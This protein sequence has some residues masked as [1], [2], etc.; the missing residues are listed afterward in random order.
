M[1]K[2]SSLPILLLLFF[3][4]FA[5]NG[6]EAHPGDSCANPIAIT[7]IAN[8]TVTD[9]L[10]TSGDSVKWFSFTA[11]YSRLTIETDLSI[12]VADT[13]RAYLDSLIIYKGNTCGSLVRVAYSA[14]K[15]GSDTFPSI[16]LLNFDS[17]YKYYAKVIRYRVGVRGCHL[18]PAYFGLAPILLAHPVFPAGPSCPPCGPNLLCNG[19]FEDTNAVIYR[20]DLPY[21]YDDESY[22]YPDTAAVHSYCIKSLNMRYGTG[23]SL[24]PVAPDNTDIYLISEAPNCRS[25]HCTILSGIYLMIADA[26]SNSCTSCS[27]RGG[28]IPTN[29]YIDTSWEEQENTIPGAMYQFSG[30]LRDADLG[31]TPGATVSISINSGII[32]SDVIDSTNYNNWTNVTYCWATTSSTA[33]IVI[34]GQ[35]APSGYGYDYETDSLTFELSSLPVISYTPGYKVCAGDSVTMTSSYLYLNSP[36]LTY[37]WAPHTGLSCYT[38]PE[39]KASP[40]VTTVY[41]CIIGTTQGSC[42]DTARVK[43][44]ASK[45]SISTS[46]NSG[47]YLANNGS[48]TV[49][50]TGGVS[51]YTYSWNPSGQTTATATG[52]SAGSYTI[53]VTDA[54]GC[55]ASA[56]VTITAP[57]AFT[58]TMGSPTN[59][60]C[61]GGTGSVTVTA[62][63][64]TSPY[65]YLW[66]PSGGT[67]ATG[68][69][70][71]AG[72][73]TV[74]ITDKD[75]CTAT[76]SVAITQPK[77]LS[78]IVNVVDP[79]SGG[80][81]IH[82]GNATANPSGGAPAYT[83]SWSPSGG[84]NAAATHLS[85]GTY[86]VTVTDAHGCTG[87]AT[88]I[89]DTLPLP[90]IIINPDPEVYCIGSPADTLVAS[91][92]VTYTWT[93]V[94]GLSCHICSSPLVSPTAT[95]TY[96]VQG[97]D[98]H[99]CMGTQTITVTVDTCCY[100]PGAIVINGPDTLGSHSGVSLSIN[101]TVT[102]TGTVTIAQCTSVEMGGYS[103]II[104]EPGATLN[105]NSSRLWGC[106]IMWRGILVK[107]G[108]TL[109]VT[110]S[111]STYRSIIEDALIGIEAEPTSTV[112]V[113]GSLLNDNYIDCQIDSTGSS[114]VTFFT[115]NADTLTCTPDGSYS[116][117]TLKYPYTGRANSYIGFYLNNYAYSGGAYIGDPTVASNQNYFSNMN[118]GV[119]AV[120]SSI[121]VYN[122][123]FKHLL[124]TP[125]ACPSCPLPY[126]VAVYAIGTCIDTA[127]PG[128]AYVGDISYSHPYGGNI[129][130]SCYA[131][132][133]ITNYFTTTA[134]YNKLWSVSDRL[135]SAYGQMG[136]N[137]ET[138]FPRDS[139]HYGSTIANHDTIANYFIGVNISGI[140]PGLSGPFLQIDSNDIYIT[141]STSAQI[142]YGISLQNFASSPNPSPDFDIFSN[143]ID[144]AVI[145]IYVDGDFNLNS[146]VAGNTILVYPAARDGWGYGI[147]VNYS[148]NVWP[149]NNYVSSQR[150]LLNRILNGP[151]TNLA[152]IIINQDWYSTIACNVIGDVGVCIGGWELSEDA[153]LLGNTF[154]PATAPTCYDGFVLDYNGVLQ[155]FVEPWCYG[156]VWMPPPSST[157]LHSQTNTGT[158]SNPMNSILYVSPSI[159]DQ[160]PNPN[161]GLLAYSYLPP[162]ISLV[163]ASLPG[164]TCPSNWGPNYHRAIER[165]TNDSL[166]QIQHQLDKVVQDSIT[167]YIFIPETKYINKF[168]V[169]S[170]ISANNQLMS[171]DTI[172]QNFYYQTQQRN[173]G[174]IDAIYRLMLKGDNS[175]AQNLNDAFAPANAI[176]Q[177]YKDERT[178]F[179]NTIAKGIR[180][181]TREQ[182]NTLWSIANQCPYQGG[183][184]VHEARYML[185]YFHHAPYQFTD[186]CSE[187]SVQK[188]SAPEN[189]AP[190]LNSFNARVYPNPANT[191]LNV[192]VQLLPNETATICLYNS[193]GQRV[194]CEPLTGSFTTLPVPGISSGIYYYRITDKDN[195]LIR[196]DKIMIIH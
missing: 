182:L 181:P 11:P 122:N 41:T 130:Q 177:N 61:F 184:G 107:P 190:A 183:F 135:G 85:L 43:I 129:I 50:D 170:D 90:V 136:I 27:V 151:D 10:F 18:C 169:Y 116:P 99:G 131:G 103:R 176:E 180:I 185:N 105:I 76:A 146:D 78:I 58:A 178:V 137:I 160:R 123:V 63:G 117:G 155:G 179:F 62:H 82:Y 149:V 104:V 46:T 143:T 132:V 56:S 120:N 150:T 93:P 106:P 113:T 29:A 28:P 66:A 33:N 80:S 37:S 188:V 6:A 59:P 163:N 162:H 51:P 21:C 173:M 5:F 38:C 172:L 34:T 84:T 189:I 35:G 60:S 156:N 22:K 119:Y 12:N 83:Y 157:Y 111:V 153:Q 49:S 3:L 168:H 171:G 110:Q 30:W 94:S 39:P 88:A 13:P 192:E 95:T 52:L 67:S 154:C 148:N 8:P 15:S 23:G 167:Y 108:G 97:T 139:V 147:I 102:V 128:F 69:G 40:S 152:G 125:A 64:G 175:A 100:S 53:T 165:S 115:V 142:L 70:L 44:L 73:Y 140:P 92:A 74:T 145:G 72:V 1:K 118:Y 134:S 121:L 14:C 124:G 31:S 68:T 36:Q 158:T 89:I 32:F 127:F 101:G 79:C 65:T 17:G 4:V 57:T 138:R 45:M 98:V 161:A 75:G 87:T 186:F 54:I 194:M 196:A 174:M 86:T 7:P 133:E 2:Q 20:H 25:Y 42:T 96:T 48:A 191:L 16:Q 126:G 114:Q 159:A 164:P 109:N 112:T 144:S 187:S 195:N 91:G 71:T 19:N 77:I 26:P 55:T 24:Y 166:A 81:G 47:C 193:L 141:D 9:Y